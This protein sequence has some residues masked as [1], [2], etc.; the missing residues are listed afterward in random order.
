MKHVYDS[1]NEVSIAAV[2]RG[3]G[4]H[5]DSVRRVMYADRTWSPRGERLLGRVYDKFFEE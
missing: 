3:A 1:T 5:P 4:N 2:A